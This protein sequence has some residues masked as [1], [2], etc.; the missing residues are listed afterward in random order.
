MKRFLGVVFAVSIVILSVFSA[1]ASDNISRDVLRGDV[2]DDSYITIIDATVVQKSVSAL[3]VLGEAQ[4]LLADVSG[5]GIVDILDATFIQQYLAEKIDDFPSAFEDEYVPV[6]WREHLAT[7]AIQINNQLGNTSENHCS[8]FWYNDSHWNNNSK[9]SPYILRY[10]N[11]HTDIDKTN[12]GGDIVNNEGDVST[13]QGLKEMEYLRQWREMLIGIPNHHSIIGNH[14]DGN[15]TNNLFPDEFIYSF[16]FEDEAS[17]DVIWGDGFYYYIDNEKEKTRYIYLDSA[18]KGATIEQLEFLENA[19]LSADD[20]YHFV[21]F[22]H[23]WY[24]PDYENYHIRPIPIKGLDVNATKF[25]SVLDSYNL[26]EGKF[27][28]CNGYVEFCLGGHVHIDYSGYSDS[29]I[30]IIIT[31][32]DCINDRGSYISQFNSISESS[33]NAVVADFDKREINIIRVGRG[34]NITIKY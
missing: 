1:G 18:Y 4:V 12:Y 11:R 23:I 3:L 7:K 29:G 2:D 24:Q 30:P 6:Y 17:E 27:S 19:L 32:A 33:V 20:G 8:F 25:L 13:E 16:L 34:D 10:L 5:N 21:V 31:E 14:D 9:K 28:D 15:K 22:S 26:R